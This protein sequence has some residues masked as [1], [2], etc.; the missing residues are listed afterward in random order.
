MLLEY[1]S[2][3]NHAIWWERNLMQSAENIFGQYIKTKNFPKYIWAAFSIRKEKLQ[4][5][6]FKTISGKFKWQNVSKT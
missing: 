3:E 5:L 4:E 2:L 6:S 1:W